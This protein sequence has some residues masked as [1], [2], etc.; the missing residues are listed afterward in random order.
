MWKQINQ[1]YGLIRD[2]SVVARGLQMANPRRVTDLIENF[3][4][5]SNEWLCTSVCALVHGDTDDYETEIGFDE[6]SDVDDFYCDCKYFEEH[7]SPCK[8]LV[9]LANVYAMQ[10]SSSKNGRNQRNIIGKNSI[11]LE[12]NKLAESIAAETVVGDINIMP[13]IV[14][15]MG[16]LNV[17]FKIGTDKFYVVKDLADLV[18]RFDDETTY[19]YGEKLVFKHS[20]LRLSENSRV[21]LQ[22]MRNMVKFM[23]G[24]TYSYYS[25]PKIESLPLVGELSEEIFKQC[26]DTGV[27]FNGYKGKFICKDE[28]SKLDITII[29]NTANTYQISAC[30]MFFAIEG[31]KNCFI[32]FNDSFYKCDFNAYRIIQPMAK[33][34]GG[35]GKIIMTEAHLAEWVKNI[36]PLLEPYFNIIYVEIDVAKYKPL[37]LVAEF[38]LDVTDGVIEGKLKCFYGDKQVDIYSSQHMKSGEGALLSEVQ[39]KS[40]LDKYFTFKNNIHTIENEDIQ[41]DFL[42]GGIIEIEKVCDIFASDKF[43]NFSV[44]KKP[45]VNVG[46][47]LDGELLN[48]AVT[49][50]GEYSNDEILAILSACK[51]KKKYVKL[52]ANKFVDLIGANYDVVE[53]ISEISGK[54]M[55]GIVGGSV[56]ASKFRALHLD[57]IIKADETNYT[58]NNSFKDLIKSIKSFEDADFEVEP[59]LD[60]KLRHYQKV[61]FR[62]FKALS[63]YGF[64]GI[65]A[66]DMGLGK[67]VQTV[68]FLQSLPG[69]SLVVCPSSLI[70]NWKNEFEKFAPQ[71]RVACIYGTKSERTDIINN[72]K[73]YDIIVTSY[74]LLKKDIDGY[75]DF[76]FEAAILDEGQ[77]IK[78]HITLNAKA[79]KDIK[80][81]YRFALTGTP[82]ENNIAELWSIFD[83][84]M[85]DYLYNYNKFKKTF[86]NKIVKEKDVK[87]TERLRQMVAPFVLR[88]LKK[89]VLKELPDKID[90]LVSIPL[91]DEQ[92][93]LYAANLA[94]IKGE[95]QG[96]QDY[97]KG[98]F[99]VLSYLLKLRQICCS[100]SLIAENYSGNSAKMD[101]CIDLIATSVANGHKVLLFSQFTSLL[102]IIKEKLIQMQISHFLLQ[103]DTKKETRMQMV[104]DFNSDDTSVF[105]LS[106]KAG[107]TGLNLTAAD[108]VIHYDPWWNLSVQN[109]AT[110][111]AHRIG[112]NKSVQV[113]RLILK[114]TIEEKIVQLQSRKQELFDSIIKE[115]EVDFTKMSKEQLLD[116]LEN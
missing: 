90:N 55:S 44:N 96:I 40:A 102:A 23:D 4:D 101:S 31:S 112:Q 104:N 92:R 39:L 60:K 106:L 30:N 67:S 98:K 54:S 20:D 108:V 72:I 77:Y 29:K 47:K 80:S 1:I 7:S 35:D 88:R 50:D 62:W 48:I 70:L 113:Y 5:D 61:G 111:R 17:R 52:S 59:S 78:N 15:D 66:D 26:R 79:V 38:Y 24:G 71:M 3:E 16:N 95:I 84:I 53:D 103:G 93:A 74:E 6:N 116:L 115:G 87:A 19:K 13:N 42:M 83:F 9:A 32:L 109:Q 105:L 14:Y 73:D 21:Y 57:K 12:Y 28:L 107:G 91:E 34:L 58:R 8:H 65:L 22:H 110:D 89:D 33:K 100:P 41:Y 2:K 45:A 18:K 82:I 56:T 11:F 46:I 27:E 49:F 85:P 97:S 99:M 86:E 51:S 75:A 76:N 25:H 69:T 94:V 37:P 114:D 43:N 81:K 10:T 68:A 64:G 63:Y 36:A